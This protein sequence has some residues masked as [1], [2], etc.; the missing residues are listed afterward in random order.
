MTDNEYRLIRRR[1]FNWI[2]FGV[3]LVIAVLGYAVYAVNDARENETQARIATEEK[4]ACRSELAAADDA[5]QGDVLV[6]VGQ[7]LTDAVTGI[8]PQPAIARFVE[9]NTRMQAAQAA[10]ANQGTSCT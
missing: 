1:T 3:L 6:A 9:A 4:L 2:G 5:A 8:D 7:A 10:R